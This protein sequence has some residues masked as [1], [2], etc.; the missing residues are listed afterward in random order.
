MRLTR[1]RKTS[2][3][4]RPRWR[5][6]ARTSTPASR[7]ASS[8]PSRTCRRRAADMSIS[9]R[10]ALDALERADRET[11]ERLGEAQ[12]TVD[13]LQAQLADAKVVR[14]ALIEEAIAEG[15]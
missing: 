4:T 10:E 8:T 1:L 11:S 6:C 7:G 5:S 12:R 3:D 9:R 15:W 13:E 2:P 14:L